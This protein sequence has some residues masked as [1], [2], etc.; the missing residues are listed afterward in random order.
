MNPDFN[1]EMVFKIPVAKSSSIF[2][3]VNIY[4]RDSEM[5]VDSIRDELYK[6]SEVKF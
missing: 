2:D 5:K 4:Q 1:E 3:K 6:R